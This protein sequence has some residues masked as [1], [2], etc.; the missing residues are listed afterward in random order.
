MADLPQTAASV[1]LMESAATVV[2]QAAE[3]ITQGQ[4]VYLAS[5][6]YY[7]ALN[8]SSAH[9]D[10]KGVALTPAAADEYFVLQTSGKMDLGATLTVGTLYS[11][12][13]TA[14]AIRPEADNGSGDFVTTLGVAVAADSLD[15]QIVASGVSKP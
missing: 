13:D 2:V 8:D 12:S 3:A 5:A 4:P 14:G 1:Q 15:L 9:A 7:K 11:V 6:K 10:C